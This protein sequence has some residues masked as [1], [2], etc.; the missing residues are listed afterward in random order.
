M[1]CR[2]RRSHR[3]RSLFR[4]HQANLG[5]YRALSFGCYP[6]PSVTLISVGLPV[7]AEPDDF[8]SEIGLVQGGADREGAWVR[9]LLRYR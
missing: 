6:R 3:H 2:D 9:W 7:R 4:A 5:C 1:R 8:L